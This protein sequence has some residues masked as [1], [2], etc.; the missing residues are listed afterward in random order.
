[1]T[2]SGICRLFQSWVRSKFSKFSSHLQH[3]PALCCGTQFGHFWTTLTTFLAS[4]S[5]IN[6]FPPCPLYSSNRCN[7]T[8]AFFASFPNSLQSSRSAINFDL[9]FRDI[10]SKTLLP[11]VCF[12]QNNWELSDFVFFIAMGDRGTAKIIKLKLVIIHIRSPS[13]LSS[14]S[15][16]VSK[17]SERQFVGD[18][19]IGLSVAL[20]TKREQMEGENDIKA[21]DLEQVSNIFSQLER[22]GKCSWKLKSAYY[23]PFVWSVVEVC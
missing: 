23:T 20:A 14:S 17:D 2:S 3:F 12:A 22:V 5:V 10:F 13:S 19:D 18:H 21:M 16:S 8:H 11:S 15:P 6:L 4:W 7:V 1:M 9:P